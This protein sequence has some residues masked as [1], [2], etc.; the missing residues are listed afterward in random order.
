MV[1]IDIVTKQEI[2]YFV[3][4]WIKKFVLMTMKLNR[5]VSLLRVR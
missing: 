2:A 4:K 3:T 5:Y 1:I